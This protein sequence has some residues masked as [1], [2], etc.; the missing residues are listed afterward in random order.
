MAEVP[1]QSGEETD[2][3]GEAKTMKWKKS[4]G[5]ANI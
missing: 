3:N 5:K 2:I 1:E 4:G